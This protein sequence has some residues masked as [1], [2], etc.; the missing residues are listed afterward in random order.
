[1]CCFACVSK[2]FQNQ[3]FTL[4]QPNFPSVC[5]VIASRD[6]EFATTTKGATQLIHAS[7]LWTVNSVRKED[8]TIWRCT[9]RSSSNC[10]ALFLTKINHEGGDGTDQHDGSQARTSS[11]RHCAGPRCF[12]ATG[13]GASHLMKCVQI[14]QRR[15]RERHP[16]GS[17][18]QSGRRMRRLCKEACT[19]EMNQTL[20][21]KN[22]SS[23]LTS[24]A[25]SRWVSLARRFSTTWW[26]HTCFRCLSPLAFCSISQQPSS[27]TG[28]FKWFR[29]FGRNSTQCI[30][31]SKVTTSLWCTFCCQGTRWACTGK[32][33]PPS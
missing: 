5:L 18:C 20:V 2:M 12:T 26:P 21:F 9:C 13:R 16:S 15:H 28:H 11:W 23:P 1:M 4:W 30:C 7:F 29:P 25:T 32:C 14:F 10:W 27:L 19:R 3:A 33:R 24:L 22:W 6:F 17:A 31:P 8:V